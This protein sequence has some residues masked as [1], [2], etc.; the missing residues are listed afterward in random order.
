[1]QDWTVSSTGTSPFP[2]HTDFVKCVA[3][4]YTADKQPLVVSG[5]ADGDVRFWTPQGQ[6]L[7][8]LKPNA[9]AIE[10]IVMDPFSEADKPAVMFST[11][12]R[13][14]FSVTLPHLSQVNSKGLQLSVPIIAHETSVYK[15]HFDSDGDLWTASADKSSKRLVRENGWASDTVLPHPDFVRDVVTHDR[16]GLVLT[17]CRDEEVRVW[18][19]GSGTLRHVFSGHFEEVTGLALLGD[20]LIS[21]SIDATLRRWSLAPQDLRRAIDEAKNPDLL[22]QAPEPASDL[23]MLTAEEEAELRAMMEDEEA[24]TME[25]M[26]KGD[27]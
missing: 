1:V 5:G 13:E 27:Q 8:T 10:C 19:R 2:A 26:A 15:L 24:D 22:K 4:V 12:Q 3:I 17:A 7:A 16:Y 23:G 18:D 20:L 14:I 11:S 9:R 21:V 25:K 6:A